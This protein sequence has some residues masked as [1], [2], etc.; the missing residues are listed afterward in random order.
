MGTALGNHCC[1][2]CLSKTH[3]GSN[4]QD[5]SSSQKAAL[6]GLNGGAGGWGQ[7]GMNMLKDIVYKYFVIVKE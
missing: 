3:T 6:T 2:N 4:L 5:L 7:S 1:Y